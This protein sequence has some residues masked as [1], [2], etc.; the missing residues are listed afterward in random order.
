MNFRDIHITDLIPQR[1]PIVMVDRVTSYNIQDAVTEFMLRPDCLFVDEDKLS[2]AGIIENMAQS[3]AARMGC[4]NMSKGK[5]VEI[6]FIGDIRNC[7]ILQLPHVG[8]V[9]TTQVHVLEDFFNLTLAEI[10]V[11][12]K[13]RV[14]AH[15]MMKI[16]T[17][18]RSDNQEE[19]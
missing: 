6:G 15:G 11:R 1:V 14:I 3:C 18:S 7:E 5:G 4:V 12:E 19:V 2:P 13:K 17:I 8:E 16:A 10:T 9:L